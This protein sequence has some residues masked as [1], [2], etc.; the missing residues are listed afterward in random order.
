MKKIWTKIKDFLDLQPIQS[1]SFEEETI[2]VGRERVWDRFR[3]FNGLSE[4]N[5]LPESLINRM[6]AIEIVAIE[7]HSIEQIQQ[8]IDAL[9]AHQSVL[10]NLK[11]MALRDAR[12]AVDLISGSTYALD[13]HQELIGESV[14][15]FTPSHLHITKIGEVEGQAG[16]VGKNL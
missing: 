14:F 3:E 13:G 10:L 8:V 16:G 1:D 7:L 15:L 11:G 4:K 2:T 9:L 5:L 12:R 6:G